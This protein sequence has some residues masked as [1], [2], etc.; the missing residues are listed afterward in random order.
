MREK[1][2][3]LFLPALVG[4]TADPSGD[5]PAPDGLSGEDI[6]QRVVDSRLRSFVSV[7]SL[8]SGNSSRAIACLWFRVV[9]KDFSDTE[10]GVESRAV[11]YLAKPFAIRHTGYY[12]Q[13]NKDDANDEFLWTRAFGFTR[14]VNLRGV[15]IHGTDFTYEDVV[16]QETDGFT[17]RRTED[18]IFHDVP[19]YVV[20][21]KPRPGEPSDYWRIL[22]FVDKVRNVVLY[23]LYY[24]TAYVPIRELV[25]PP[26]EVKKFGDSWVPMEMT[27]RSLTTGSYT[28]LRVDEF[29]A[30]PELGDRD[31]DMRRLEG[32]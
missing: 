12:L 30:N 26:K 15:G 8:T 22:V 25:I 32:H 6:Y 5:V 24:N 29:D 2:L 16:P 23:A 17:Y 1:L 21:L 27:M 28:T 9:W 18:T 19:V 20:E 7:A 3:L 11:I 10:P 14:R 13:V 31:F 4:L